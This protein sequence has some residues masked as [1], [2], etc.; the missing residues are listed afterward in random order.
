MDAL[1]SQFEAAASEAQGGLEAAGLAAFR[2]GRFRREALEG[3]RIEFLGQKQ[4][5]VALAQERSKALFKSFSPDQKRE[6]GQRFNAVKTALEA[7]FEGAKSRV[8]RPAAVAGVDVSP[9]ACPVRS[10]AICTR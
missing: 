7:A 3:A 10:W 8:D 1:A 5:Q 2:I 6:Y 9:P 4:G